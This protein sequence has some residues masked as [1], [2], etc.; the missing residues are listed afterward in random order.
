MAIRGKIRDRTDRRYARPPL[1]SAVEDLNRVPRGWGNYFRY[2]N[3]A[4]KFAHIDA[5]VNE[6]LALLASAKHGLQGRNWAPRFNDEWATQLGIHRLTGT[7]KP[8]RAH[9]SR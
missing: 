8:T 2:G 1:E 6:R 3:S 9:A 4:R 7:V 5:H